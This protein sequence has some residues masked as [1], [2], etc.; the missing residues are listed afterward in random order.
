MD[1]ED[2]TRSQQA[3]P[4][5]QTGYSAAWILGLAVLVLSVFGLI[6][7]PHWIWSTPIVAALLGLGVNFRRRTIPSGWASAGFALLTGVLVVGALALGGLA[8]R[9]SH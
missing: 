8:A 3:D 6:R 1:D 4:I 2:M 9:V 5:F 7:F